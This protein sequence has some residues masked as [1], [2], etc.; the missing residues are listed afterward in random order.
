MSR[1]NNLVTV[2]LIV[3]SLLFS[4]TNLF[5]QYDVGFADVNLHPDVKKIIAEIE[6]K[7]KKTI[8]VNYGEFEK[9][10]STTFGTSFINDSG[11]ALVNI[12]QD[13]LNQPKKLE[14]VVTHELLHLKLR[15]NGFPVFLW[16]STIKTAKGR[17]IDVEQSSVNDLLSLIEHQVFKSDMEK[18]DLFK[19]I[20]LAGDTAKFARIN[21]NKRDSQADSL[22]YARAI[23][24]YHN[25][26]DI[27]EVRKIYI[28]NKW[29][30]SLQQGKQ[31]AEI[32]KT[33][34][35]QNPN[36]VEKTFLR[37]L[38][39]LFPLPNANYTFK[40]TVDPKS[41]FEKQMIIS[42]AKK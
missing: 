10:N 20:N 26:A 31:I 42:I 39:V 7:T 18:Y 2:C 4:S 29:N 1:Q 8:E 5:A 36:D 32:I 15:V 35:S 23:L 41:K 25:P 13:L 33:S 19:I 14:A 34:N 17:A 21:R 16:S 30:T 37:C 3:L 12:R 28:A 27:E 6:S 40:L 9:D 24:E 38:S 11:R 22:N